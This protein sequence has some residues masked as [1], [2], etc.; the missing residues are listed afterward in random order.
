MKK[1]ILLVLCLLASSTGAQAQSAS[2]AATQYQARMDAFMA[3][4]ADDKRIAVAGQIRYPL[5][6]WHDGEEIF[7]IGTPADFLAN[8]E[9][10]FTDRTR[11]MLLAID[12]SEYSRFTAGIMIGDGEIWFDREA[13]QVV[14]LN[15]FENPV[16]LASVPFG[17]AYRSAKTIGLEE[18]LWRG[19]RYTTD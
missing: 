9:T 11:P 5:R 16:A 14:T 13:A 2:E 8:Y 12:T 7:A 18:F 15:I 10:I 4:L 1:S 19:E 3:D 17:E 6:F